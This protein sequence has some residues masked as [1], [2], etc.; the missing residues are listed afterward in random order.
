M[1][2]RRKKRNRTLIENSFADRSLKADERRRCN[3][4]K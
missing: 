3:G 2:K 1:L 4:R